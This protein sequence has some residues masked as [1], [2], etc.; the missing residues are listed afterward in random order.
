METKK[1]LAHSVVELLNDAPTAGAAQEEFERVFQR[2]E[3][4]EDSATEIEWDVLPFSDD[5]KPPQLI[6]WRDL[7]FGQLLLAGISL[8]DYLLAR[9]A[10]VMAAS[11]VSQVANVSM[12]EA[13]RLIQQG[14]VSVDGESVTKAIFNVK[15][16]SLVKI[17][18]HRF[19][20][21]GPPERWV[22]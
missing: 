14:A 6:S 4:P 10:P 7:P 9:G 12:S 16:G 1:R 3:K 22:D 11:F 19:F 8:R 20:K 5:E 21:I 15:P 17:G 2:R 18:R 13:R